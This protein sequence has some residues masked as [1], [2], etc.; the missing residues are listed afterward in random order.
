MRSKRRSIPGSRAG[1]NAQ[2]TSHNWEHLL[3]A[4]PQAG[5]RGARRWLLADL[6]SRWSSVAMLAFHECAVSLCSSGAHRATHR[7]FGWR[8]G[9]TETLG[10]SALRTSNHS[11]SRKLAIPPPTSV[12]GASASQRQAQ[13]PGILGH[14][15]A[16]R[17]RSRKTLTSAHHWQRNSSHRSA[18]S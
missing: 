6:H 7:G 2:R 12:L 5:W 17:F 11:A 10:W 18:P 8:L 16:T 15:P 13:P 3:Q 14:P 1:P 4:G 9:E